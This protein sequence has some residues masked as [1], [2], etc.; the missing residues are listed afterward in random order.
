LPLGTGN[1]RMSR[2][3]LKFGGDPDLFQATSA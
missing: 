1:T 3:L 2:F